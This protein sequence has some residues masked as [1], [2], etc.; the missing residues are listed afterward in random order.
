MVR[1]LLVENR[2]V[3]LIFIAG[4][5]LAAILAASMSTADSQLLAS[6]SAFAS[7]FYKPVL[8]KK[9]GEKEM[10]W[11]GRIMV[12]VISVVALLIAMNPDMADIM[13]LVENAWGAFGASFGP[14]VVL[15]LYWKRLTYAGALAGIIAGFATDA[16]WLAFLSSS[17]GLYEIIPGFI[18]GL[19]V[20]V[21]VSKATPAPSQEVLDIFEKAK[22]K[23]G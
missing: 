16:L 1:K 14:A 12:A 22:E 4:I 2:G 23:I 15:A 19:I 20:A 17:T 11:A 5:L 18:V 13:G 7:D 6:A 9:A 10:L 3:I 8:R 21:L